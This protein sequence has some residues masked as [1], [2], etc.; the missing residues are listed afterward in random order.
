MLHCSIDIPAYLEKRTGKKRGRITSL[1]GFKAS[2]CLFRP[3]KARH[4][5]DLKKFEGGITLLREPDSFTSHHCNLQGR[6]K[7]YTAQQLLKPP[8]LLH[9][10]RK[11]KKV[12]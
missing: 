5:P 7:I 8:S 10:E 4:L 2:E 11:K 3:V 12:K 1:Q 9:H 6:V